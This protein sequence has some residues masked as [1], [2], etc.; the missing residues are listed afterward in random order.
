MHNNLYL[1]NNVKFYV[2]IKFFKYSK[3]NNTLLLVIII[4]I[5]KNSM[6]NYFSS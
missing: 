2:L 6:Y 1:D 5:Q 4:I 3:K